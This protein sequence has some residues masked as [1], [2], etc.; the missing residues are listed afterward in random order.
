MRFVHKRADDQARMHLPPFKTHPITELLVRQ[1]LAQY[2][3]RFKPIIYTIMLITGM[4]C[5]FF[6]NMYI[7]EKRVVSDMGAVA[8]MPTN[9]RVQLV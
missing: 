1:K 3:P 9:T 6:L 7:Y 2:F 4:P 5:T 8:Q